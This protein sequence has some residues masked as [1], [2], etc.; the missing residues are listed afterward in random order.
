MSCIG[1]ENLFGDA[2]ACHLTRGEDVIELFFREETAVQDDLA[3][4]LSCCISLACELGGFLIPDVR[5]E[6]CDDTDAVVKPLLTLI[7]V[8]SAS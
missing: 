7:D 4:G 1:R 8:N 6:R 5:Q 2:R 3:D